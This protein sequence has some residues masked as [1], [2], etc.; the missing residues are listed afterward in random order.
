MI[1]LLKTDGTAKELS[2]PL[3][4]EQLQELVGGYIEIVFARVA[5]KPAQFV[6]DEEGLLKDRP[7]N[8]RASYLAGR[9]LVGDV[10]VLTGRDRLT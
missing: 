1:Q 8:E 9:P 5:R 7:Y 6:V 3:G 10:V 2:G 4:L